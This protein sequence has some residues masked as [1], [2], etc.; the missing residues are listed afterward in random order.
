MLDVAPVNLIYRHDASAS[1]RLVRVATPSSHSVSRCCSLFSYT[2]PAPLLGYKY[3]EGNAHPCETICHSTSSAGVRPVY[4]LPIDKF[5]QLLPSMRSLFLSF[6]S[7]F[8]NNIL[9]SAIDITIDLFQ[10]IFCVQHVSNLKRNLLHVQGLS[11][12]LYGYSEIRRRLRFRDQPL[13]ARYIRRLA[14][15]RVQRV[16]E[17]TQNCEGGHLTVERG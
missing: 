1:P 6:S 13:A 9:S 15:K 17:M 2:P 10:N 8:A 7:S 3:P 12:F 11:Y 4:L 16:S 5:T 14:A